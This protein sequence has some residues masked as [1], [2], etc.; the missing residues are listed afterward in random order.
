MTWRRVIR[1]LS[2]KLLWGLIYAG[3]FL[4]FFC[5]AAIHRISADPLHGA[6]TATAK[7]VGAFYRN[8]SY[9]AGESHKYDLYLPKDT[10]RRNYGLVVFLHAGGFTSGDKSEDAPMLRRFASKGYVAAGINYTL[11]DEDAPT[12]SVYD[13]SLEI[14]QAIPQIVEESRRRGFAV[15]KMAIAG[16]APGVRSRSSTRFAMGKPRPYR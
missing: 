9:G 16:G 10:T 7:D 12:T 13:Q 8:L 4:L 14:Q 15:D 5:G 1:Y 2:G 6:Y 11:C 3:V